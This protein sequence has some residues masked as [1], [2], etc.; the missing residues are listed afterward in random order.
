MSY[1]TEESSTGQEREPDPIYTWS[2]P[3]EWLADKVQG[4]NLDVARATAQAL[5]RLVEA[6]DLQHEFQD[7]MDEDGYFKD[8]SKDSCQEC[9]EPIPKG[10]VFCFDC[11]RAGYR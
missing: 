2:G 9:G 7:E 1:A 6:D 3:H 10:D 5:L 8:L 4:M 11:A